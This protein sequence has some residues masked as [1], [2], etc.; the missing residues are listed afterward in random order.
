[1]VAEVEQFPPD[2]QFDPVAAASEKSVPVPVSDTL[3]G[4]LAASSVIVT[5]AVRAPLAVGLKVTVIMQLDP[6]ARVELL[7]GHV[8]F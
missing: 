5:D 6:A 1:M 8:L 4:L 2:G 7:A 3:W